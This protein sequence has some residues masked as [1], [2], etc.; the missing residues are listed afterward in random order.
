L[1]PNLDQVRQ[2]PLEWNAG[3]SVDME[4]QT[5]GERG[6]EN[7]TENTSVHEI[8]LLDLLIVL[9]DRR[10]FLLWFTLSVSVVAV[11]AT[12]I[13]PSQYT[14][15]TVVLPPAG[16]S[17]ASSALLGQLAGSSGLASMA[18]ASLGIKNPG[19]MYVALFGLPAIEDALIQHF[20]LKARYHVKNISDARR[21]FESHATVSLGTKDGLI[22]ISVTDR[23]PNTAAEIANAYVDEFRK[24]SAKLAVTEASQRRLFFQ[25]QMLEANE[26]LATAE[27]AMKSTEQSTG[28]LQVDSQA[29]ALI[30]SAALLRGQ[31]GA[32]EVELQALRS[33]GTENNPQIVVAKQELEELKAQLTQLSGKNTNSS[34]DII[35]AK[36]GLP[37]AQM[38]YVRKLRD[39]HYY[40]AIEEILAKQFEMAKLD[41]AREGAVVQV[42]EVAMPPDKRSSPKRTLIVVVA[43]GLSF[44][45]ACG[46][47]VIADIVRRSANNPAD[48]QRL[49]ALRA[50]F[51]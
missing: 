4:S 10:K 45:G 2:L 49:D 30:E 1:T 5:N 48:R 9:S 8:H 36:G 41:E 46:W 50:T 51:R 7:E 31:I 43:T 18:G 40:E 42:A 14:A 47:F 16:N 15:E 29:R 39:L 20:E 3:V 21:A 23:D 38:A 13:I 27:E 22:R 6:R 32:K 11:I 25:Q 19:D 17:S 33:Y 12:L 26:N 28:V 35:P 37:A 44:F 34:A 24:F